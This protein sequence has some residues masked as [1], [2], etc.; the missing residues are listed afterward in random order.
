[1]CL[2]VCVCVVCQSFR[3][4]STLKLKEKKELKNKQ[5]MLANDLIESS[6]AYSMHATNDNSN[7][8]AMIEKLA[9]TIKDKLTTV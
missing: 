8:V 9:K 5:K 4:L 6:L 7:I 2:C 1:M 3:L